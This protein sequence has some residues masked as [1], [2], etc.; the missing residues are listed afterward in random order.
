MLYYTYYTMRSPFHVP[1]PMTHIPSICI[2]RTALR[3]IYA[4]RSLLYTPTLPLLFRSSSTTTTNDHV[5][6]NSSI[7]IAYAHPPPCAP[8]QTP[9]APTSPLEKLVHRVERKFNTEEGGGLSRK[10]I[11]KGVMSQRVST[12]CEWS[13]EGLVTP[14]RVSLA[15]SMRPPVR[16]ACVP[17]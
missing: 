11:H 10:E 7:F 3:E 5:A 16:A 15:L 2:S 12:I 13:Q 4:L 17:P 9:K 14:S 8:C 1:W 6:H